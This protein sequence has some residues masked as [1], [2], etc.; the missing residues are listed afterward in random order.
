[1]TLFLTYCMKNSA[2]GKPRKKNQQCSQLELFYSQEN[3]CEAIQFATG[4]HVAKVVSIPDYIRYKEIEKF[5]ATAN[6]LTSHLK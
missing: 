2:E 3:N 1:M 5:Y 4:R 6:K